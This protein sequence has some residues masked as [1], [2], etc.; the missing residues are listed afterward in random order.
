MRTT[1]SRLRLPMLAAAAAL[2]LGA[3]SSSL[4]APAAHAE[5]T[6]R[7]EAKPVLLPKL[8]Q[9]TKALAK[10]FDAIPADR[11]Q[12]LDKLALFVRTKRASGEKAKLVFICTHNSRR[13]HM[14]QLWSTVAAASYGIDNVETFSGGVETTAFNPR[15]VAALERAGFRITNPGG[16]NPHYKVSFAKNRPPVEAFSKKYD[17]AT[18]PHENFAAV[19]TCT[20]ADKNCP[21]IQGASLRVALPFEDPKVSDGTPKEAATYDQRAKQIAT[22]MFY[23]FSRVDTPKP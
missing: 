22:E 6:A 1:S 11:K 23:F 17:D 15:A 10:D 2:M 14:S 8:A 7:V 20:Q 12:T 21:S 18:N 5:S 9:Y 13:S 16:E 19:M 4:V 3:A